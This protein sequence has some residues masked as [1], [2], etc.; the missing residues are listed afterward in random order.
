MFFLEDFCMPF[1][2]KA[3]ETPS[4]DQ[5]QQDF[6]EADEHNSHGHVMHQGLF[7]DESG[8]QHETFGSVPRFVP[9]RAEDMVGGSTQGGDNFDYGTSY[10]SF[11]E[12]FDGHEQETEEA[13]DVPNQ[14]GLI[15]QPEERHASGGIPDMERVNQAYDEDKLSIFQYDMEE[16]QWTSVGAL[17]HWMIAQTIEDHHQSLRIDGD[18]QYCHPQD[19]DPQASQEHQEATTLAR[20]PEIPRT[21]SSPSVKEPWP[22]LRKSLPNSTPKS[23]PSR[24]ELVSSSLLVAFQT[25]LSRRHDMHLTA[26][27]ASPRVETPTPR[28]SRTKVFSKVSEEE[29]REPSSDESAGMGQQESIKDIMHRMSAAIVSADIIIQQDTPR[30]TRKVASA[31]PEEDARELYRQ[32]SPSPA[33]RIQRGRM[34]RAGN[35]T[36]LQSSSLLDDIQESQYSD[37]LAFRP[38]GWAPP[39]TLVAQE[40]PCAPVRHAVAV[41]NPNLQEEEVDVLPLAPRS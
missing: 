26:E 23:R 37:Y 17:G 8:K 35:G 11:Y 41:A 7:S 2:D 38:D 5:L 12:S 16:P 6:I 21:A 24:N 22:Q 27:L 36:R 18:P 34:M 3:G 32:M 31:V 28:K 15:Y 9:L 19:G 29:R 39:K 10:A 13:G 30:G 40:V 14:R 20:N 25:L 33:Q 4:V 1:R